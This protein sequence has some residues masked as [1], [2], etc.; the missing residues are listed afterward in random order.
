MRARYEPCCCTRLPTS[1][2]TN[3][4]SNYVHNKTP[5][6]EIVTTS[7]FLVVV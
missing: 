4:S 1:I 7:M 6:L 2:E 3:H 5:V